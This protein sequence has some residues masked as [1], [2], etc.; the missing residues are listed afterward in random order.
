MI[1]N[2][3]VLIV[4]IGLTTYLW[5]AQGFFSSLLHLVSV[6]AAAALA[7]ALWEPIVYLVVPKINSPALVDMSWGIFLLVP[8]TFFLVIFHMT[9]EKFCPANVD[10]SHAQNL[11]GGGAVGFVS[12]VITTG[13]LLIGL[14]FVQG[15]SKL[16]GYT[17]WTS[18]QNGSLVQ[19]GGTAGH[20]WTPAD[21]WTMW[22]FS[23]ASLG[24][25]ATFEPLAKWHPDLA[26]QASLFRESYDAGASRMGMKPGHL[27]V[28]SVKRYMPPNPAGFIRVLPGID[29]DTQ[30]VNGQ[31]DIYQIE[32]A[33]NNA[34]WDDGKK[35]RLTKAQVRLVGETIDGE[36]VPVQPHA[37]IQRFVSD[38][39]A[40][41]RW[42]YDGEDVPATSLGAGSETRVGFEFLVPPGTRLNHLIIR[43]CR[44]LLPATDPQPLPEN[45][46]AQQNMLGINRD[47]AP[48][49]G[50]PDKPKHWMGYA[51][52]GILFALVIFAS[53]MPA[54][55]GHQ[56]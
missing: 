5:S 10:L 7:L 49:P 29:P 18:E 21:E 27:E 1:M 45:T 31:G 37:F 25:M 12:G 19:A 40:R 16:L 55:R 22:Y 36:Y 26:Q 8:Y 17:G 51:V 32:T 34:A 53:V 24:P 30:T 56:D 42:V 14:Q 44:T 35:L 39:A 11:I 54:K 23:Q 48:N 41:G 52:S 50:T 43:Q 6:V 13:L 2:L 9:G 28:K 4:G 33:I 38:S 3:A 20:L 47:V 15:P 46:F